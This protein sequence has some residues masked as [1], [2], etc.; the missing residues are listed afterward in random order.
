MSSSRPQAAA[1][2][3][4]EWRAQE[5]AAAVV[6]P[7]ETSLDVASAGSYAAK[8]TN[9]DLE[10]GS[11]HP[12]LL[13]AFS[14]ARC[15]L[16]VDGSASERLQKVERVVQNRLALETLRVC[17]AS[18][19]P[20]YNCGRCFKCV[21]MMLDLAGDRCPRGLPTLP[22]V[23]DP[24]TL[25]GVAALF[26][27]DT[28]M[29]DDRYARL[30]E[31]GAD[32]Q[33]LG[34]LRHGIERMRRSWRRRE[35]ALDTIRQAIPP[36]APFALFDEDDLRYDVARTHANVRPFPERNGFFN[37]LPVDDG[38]AIDELRR[39][40]RT[41]RRQPGGVEERLLGLDHYRGLG[42]LLD[43]ECRVLASTP[44]VKVY[45]LSGAG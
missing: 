39:A 4:P 2:I 38:A 8:I 3:A 44:E 27:R 15:E 35:R 6:H 11:C 40:L 37:G 25:S 45:A 22:D 19:E 26:A 41:W 29:M 10:A 5:M 21:R 23:L 9:A 34:A 12:L 31:R 32:P 14:T 7:Y 18:H 20:G 1:L 24:S 17:W 30:A 43:D 28:D 16:I 33:I 13:P 42:D 36:D